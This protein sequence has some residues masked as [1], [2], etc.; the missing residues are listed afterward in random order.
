MSR[1][2]DIFDV[3]G[4]LIEW[5]AHYGDI[6]ARVLGEAGTQAS[7]E[8]V[9]EMLLSAAGA[10]MYDQC[11]RRHAGRA[12]EREFWLDCAG[13]ALAMLGLQSDLRRWAG[14]AV[15]L[16]SDPGL[17]RL[18][19]DVRPALEALA[20]AGA[21]LGVVTGRPAAAP[22]LA[23]LG[24][25]HYFH[26]MIDGLGAGRSKRDGEMFR[27]AAAAAAQEG[28][29]AWHVGDSYADD[30]QGARAAGLRPVLVDREDEHGGA[31]C[32]RVADLSA[33]PDVIARAR[34]ED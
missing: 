24:V 3:D 16:F 13:R 19:A 23:M 12:D 11:L 17:I 2:F 32:L 34:T 29:P 31:D 22:D 14:R 25:G 4:T 33:L 26:P 30:V 27:L 5:T 7:R 1:P 9:E 15:E 10:A 18:Y 21:R 28:L 8:Q 6:Y 20:E